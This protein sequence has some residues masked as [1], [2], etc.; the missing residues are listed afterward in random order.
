MPWTSNLPRRK[1]N[2]ILCVDGPEKC[3]KTHFALS[4]APDPVLY[5]N[6][7]RDN[8]H[9]ITRLMRKGRKI[10]R[11]RR[12]PRNDYWFIRPEDPAK[13]T[14]ETR[15]KVREL[16]AAFKADYRE[17]LR[18]SSIA[19]IVVDT[20]TMVWAAV[21]LANHGKLS[22]IPEVMYP[23]LNFQMSRLINEANEF[24]KNVV[25][26]HRL[27]RDFKTGELKPDGF[28]YIGNEVD[29]MVRL[30]FTNPEDDRPQ[31]YHAEIIRSGLLGRGKTFRGKHCNWEEIV[32]AIM[33]DTKEA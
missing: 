7:D 22:Q 10:L 27:G 9:L 13:A 20:G 24:D 30:G 26:L 21:R 18:D 5:L 28:K 29:A 1:R 3:G 25:W 6:W 12:P 31:T 33:G 11:P 16:L 32:G 23:K 19:T 17:G 8:N 15:A 4:G 2:L 14:D